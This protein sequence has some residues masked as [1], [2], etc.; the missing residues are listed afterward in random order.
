MAL[1]RIS[2]KE[3]LIRLLY[4]FPLQLLILHLKK[5]HVLLLSWIIIGA[6]ITGDLAS[7]YGVSILFLYPEYLGKNGVLAFGILGFSAGGFIMAFNLYR[8][9]MHGF[10]FPFIA[11]LARP[12]LK[13]SINNFAIPLAFTILY[14]YKS[15]NYQSLKEFVEPVDIAVNLTSFVIGQI[16]FC[17]LSFAYFLSTNKDVFKFVKKRKESSNDYGLNKEAKNLNKER[18]RW[19]NLRQNRRTWRVETYL[20]SFYRVGLARD[21]IHYNNEII[22]KILAQNHINASIF[23]IIVILSFLVIG[24]LR[25]YAFFMI[26]AAAS[27]FLLFTMFLMIVSAL[28]SWFKGWTI[29]VF[30]VVLVIINTASTQTGVLNKESRAF[31]LNYENKQNYLNY[32]ESGLPT[33]EEK[34]RDKQN[35]IEALEA[36]KRQIVR[37]HGI[38]KPQIIFLNASGGGLRSALWNYKVLN[39]I[40]SITG[41]KFYD[42]VALITGSSGGMLGQAFYRELELQEELGNDSINKMTYYEDF[43]NDILNPIIFSLVT[44]DLFIRYQRIRENGFSYV[45]DRGYAFERAFNA[46]TKYLLDKK[47]GDYTLPEKRGLIPLMIYSPSSINDARKILIS[48]NPVSFLTTN[49]KSGNRPL[50]ENIDL[51]HLLPNNQSM[52]LKVTSA[53][54]MSSTF[55][56]ILPSVSLPTTPSLDVMDAGYRDNYGLTTSIAFAS[57]LEQWLRENTSA[58]FFIQI[59]DLQKVGSINQNINSSFIKKLL[60]PIETVYGNLFNTHNFAQDQIWEEFVNHSPLNIKSAIITLQ[61][62]PKDKISLSWHLSKKEKNYIN[63]GLINPKDHPE[64]DYIVREL[65]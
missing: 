9:I 18:K 15:A 11:S 31:G 38:R 51:A 49:P 12:F 41:G 32:I 33:I 26:P 55:P 6:Y 59:R 1:T 45:K 10:R 27:L 2:L 17:L 57:E 4:F 19:Q 44:N 48:S 46:N 16:I 25:D 20:T 62:N 30:I 58:V 35:I 3:R 42:H 14:C 50:A 52:D 36:W 64:I 61:K 34:H 28:Y 5:N 13:F 60:S 29:S 65:K 54:R 63:N 7:K 24:S 40:D 8:Y 56:F 47:M 23:E 43:G 22:T 37:K 39:H 53:L 21:S